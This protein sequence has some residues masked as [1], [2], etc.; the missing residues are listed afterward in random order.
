MPSESPQATYS[1]LLERIRD[2]GITRVAN[3]T[4]LDTIGIPVVMACRPN[5][6]GLSV[7][8][9]ASTDLTVAKIAAIMESVEAFHAE[10]VESPLLL[11]TYDEIRGKHSVVDIT[12]LSS[13]RNSRYDTRTRLLWIESKNLVDARRVWV[14]FEC[15]HTDFTLPL[16]TG[17]GCF[18]ASSNGLG[19]GG[20]LAQAVVHGICEVVERDATALWWVDRDAGRA[21]KRIDLSTV[22][23]H[24]CRQ[25]LEAFAAAGL[26][27]AA[28]ETTT[29]VGVPSF[30]SAIT[31]ASPSDDVRLE[32]SDGMGCHPSPVRALRRAL[33]E[34]AQSRLTLLAGARDDVTRDSYASASSAAHARLLRAMIL[35]EEARVD[36]EVARGCSDCRSSADALAWLRQ[37]ILAAGFEQILVVD[38]TREALRIPAVRVLVPGLE[39][40]CFQCDYVAGERARKRGLE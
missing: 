24:D 13:T 16:P 21:L 8:Q 33:I 26:E 23:D 12:R 34:A 35:R 3:I 36:L 39:G 22:A 11:G 37:R 32:T 15:V 20:D 30:F 29:D 9:G 38:L 31:P 18:Q 2:M 7:S 10:R 40:V 28:W 6:R 1:W 19:A 4:G 5:S 14:P 27:V 25:I 17:S